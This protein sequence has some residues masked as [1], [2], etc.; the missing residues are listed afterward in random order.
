VNKCGLS[1]IC[2]SLNLYGYPLV[3][4]L[5]QAMFTFENSGLKYI[6]LEN[7]LITK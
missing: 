1:P 7:Y 3:E 2:T 4:T 6:A 5:E